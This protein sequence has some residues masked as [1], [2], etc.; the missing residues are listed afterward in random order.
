MSDDN[1]SKVREL[2]ERCSPEERKTIFRELRSSFVIHEYERVTGATAE[3]ILEA[4]HRAPE[5]T[6]R[7]L[8]GV[9]ADAA[10]AEYVLP[11][12]LPRWHNV[13]E[14]GNFAYDYK[15]QDSLGRTVTVQ[16][17]LQRSQK[18]Q[19]VRKTGLPFGFES[20]VYFVETQKTRGGVDGDNNKT[21]P[22]RYGEFDILA[23]SLQPSVLT[24]D[25]YTYT[26]GRWLI[27]GGGANE[28]AVM[29][30]V[31]IGNSDFWTEE[32]EQAAEWFFAEVGSKRMEKRGPIRAKKRS[33]KSAVVS[34]KRKQ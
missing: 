5:L 27:A 34:K 11:H 30:P 16:V 21:R 18:G 22:Y 3:M 10:F 24:W 2:L 17:K 7:M 9:I 13:T 1:V 14:E 6:R 4:I 20:D 31:S 33:T 32:F 26:L 23:V 25:R 29:Q 8:R 15:L 19:P 28:I 12:L